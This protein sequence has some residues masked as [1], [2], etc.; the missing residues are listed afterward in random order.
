MEILCWVPEDQS[1]SGALLVH[2]AGGV[3][4]GDAFPTFEICRTDMVMGV[5]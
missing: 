1:T 5:F 4:G 2:E 3:R